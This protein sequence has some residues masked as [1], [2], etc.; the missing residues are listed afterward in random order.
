MW[1]C[2]NGNNALRMKKRSSILLCTIG[3]AGDVH[4]FIGIGQELKN[5]GHRVALITSRFFEAHARGAGLDFLASA[6]LKI[7]K[8]PSK[9]LISGILKKASRS[10]RRA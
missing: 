10:L 6:A 3:S 8:P 1:V 4:P 9:T 7:T 2:A 5:R